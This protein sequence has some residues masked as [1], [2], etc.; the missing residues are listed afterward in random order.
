LKSLSTSSYIPFQEK[1]IWIDYYFNLCQSN[2]NH[3]VEDWIYHSYNILQQD[4]V[5][6]VFHSILICWLRLFYCIKIILK[7]KLFNFKSTIK[8]NY[9]IKLHNIST[10]I[11]NPSCCH[12]WE[13]ISMFKACQI[14]SNFKIWSLEYEITFQAWC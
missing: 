11:P 14:E 3:H 6:D 7:S 5:I 10:T 2:Y 9:N 12:S 8:I 4:A 1:H 13:H